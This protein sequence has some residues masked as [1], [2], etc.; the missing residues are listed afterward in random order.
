[1]R[2]RDRFWWLLL[3]I[4]LAFCAGGVA[5]PYLGVRTIPTDNPPMTSADYWL[6]IGEFGLLT[7]VCLGSGLM[8]VVMAVRERGRHRMRLAAL[9]GDA[10]AMPLAEIHSDPDQ[11]PNVAE[12]PLELMWRVGKVA[13]VY[14]VL[15]FGFVFL[16]PFIYRASTL[17]KIA[18]LIF[19]PT[20]TPAPAYA[21]QPLNDLDVISI[22]TVVVVG[23]VFVWLA[24]HLVGR[25]CGISVTSS[26]IDALTELGSQIHMAWDEMRLL[27]VDKGDSASQRR[28]SLYAQGK[29][30]AW[31][32]YTAGLSVQ[33]VPVGATASEITLRQAALVSL[34]A[35]RTGLAP[36]TLAKAL[37]SNPPGD[38]AIP[39]QGG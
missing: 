22:V 33:Y 34:I 27:E 15:R 14:Y 11:T 31:A 19:P 4:G 12:K 6:L 18:A 20:S 35:A 29:C 32:E 23:I 16:V 2:D 36:R 7:L 37:E 28:F 24:P 9:Y 1:V 5:A 30:I 13:R 3:I 38:V 17:V 39:N 25:P 8:F 21:P 10:R 26:G